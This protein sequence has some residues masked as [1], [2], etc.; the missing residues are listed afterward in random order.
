MEQVLIGRPGLGRGLE[1][2]DAVLSGVVEESGSTGESVVEFG[3][4]P[5]GNDLDR[6]L[7]TVEGELESDLVVSLSSASVG[8]VAADEGRK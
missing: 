8:D 4:S 1:D 7:E 6:G 5:R 3:E 2:G